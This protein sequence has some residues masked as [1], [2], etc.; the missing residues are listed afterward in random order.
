[1]LMKP[2]RDGRTLG[3]QQSL[4]TSKPERARSGNAQ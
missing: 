3:N 2:T 1:M 4:E